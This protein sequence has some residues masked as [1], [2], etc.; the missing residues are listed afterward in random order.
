M[1]ILQQSKQQELNLQELEEKSVRECS[2][3]ILLASCFSESPAREIRLLESI[4]ERENM[5]RAL[6]RVIRNK[7]APGVDGMT[8]YQLKG[9]LK[10]HLPTIK[11]ALLDGVYKRCRYGVRGSISR[12]EA[13]VCSEF[14]PSSIA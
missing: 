11:Q 5:E 4:L 8:I 10:R 9:H 7:G 13:S 3:E 2:S 14:P 6:K 1:N 12:R